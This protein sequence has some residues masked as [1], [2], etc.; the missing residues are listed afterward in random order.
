ML[1]PED[2]APN[3]EPFMFYVEAFQEL[4]TCRPSG[5][6]ISAIPFVAVVEYAKLYGIEGEDFHEFLYIIRRMDSELLKLE[7]D[8]S[9]KEPKTTGTK[10]GGNPSKRN[11]G[12]N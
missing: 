8:K 6:G 9:K 11:K 4:S 1:K 5:F 3:V 2:A 12:R 10:N 7:A